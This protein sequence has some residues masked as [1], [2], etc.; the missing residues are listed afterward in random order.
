MDGKGTQ[1][2]SLGAFY[3]QLQTLLVLIADISGIR[4]KTIEFCHKIIH[5]KKKIYQSNRFLK[6]MSKLGPKTVVGDDSFNFKLKIVVSDY[7]FNLEKFKTVV[8]NYGFDE[9]ALVW[10]FFFQ[11]RIRLFFF[12]NVLFWDKTWNHEQE[13]SK[14]ERQDRIIST[15]HTTTKKTTCLCY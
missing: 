6:I 8:T 14:E 12:L 11:K 3:L 13:T 9:D 5:L 7:G 15:I 1:Y 4:G 2:I 10:N